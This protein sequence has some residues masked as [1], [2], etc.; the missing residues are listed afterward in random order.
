MCGVSG[1]GGVASSASFRLDSCYCQHRAGCIRACLL[2][3]SKRMKMHM[4]IEDLAI[5]FHK[6]LRA[7]QSQ[8]THSACLLSVVISTLLFTIA[9]RYAEYKGLSQ[10]F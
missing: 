5:D 7:S 1:I 6:L 3:C 10:Q 8:Q 4:R 2:L 9:T